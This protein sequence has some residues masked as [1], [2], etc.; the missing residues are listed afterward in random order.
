MTGA[1]RR[2]M[3]YRFLGSAMFVAALFCSSNAFAG[4]PSLDDGRGDPLIR[5]TGLTPVPSTKLSLGENV[6]VEAKIAY[7]L[8]DAAGKV[9]LVVLDDAKK[10]VAQA[11]TDVTQGTAVATLSVPIVVPASKMLTVKA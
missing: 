5:I 8:H 11:S 9:V 6:T 4:P 3:R 10:Q 1:R 7:I 2:R